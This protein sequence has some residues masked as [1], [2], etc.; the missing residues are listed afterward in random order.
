MI[1]TNGFPKAGNHALVK[2]CELL[3]AKCAVN[4]TPFGEELPG[5]ATHSLFIVRDPRDIVISFLRFTGR[6]VTAA[7]FMLA[8]REFR[9]GSS[10]MAELAK[11]EGWLSSGSLIVRYEDLIADERE[12]RRIAAFIGVEYWPRLWEEL[13]GLTWTWN[14]VHSDY[15]ALW[16]AELEAEWASAGGNDLLAIWGYEP[17]KS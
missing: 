12:M 9:P 1:F 16:T 2:A 15:R 17:W 5:A 11:Y 3:G 6:P 4:H 10:L 13:P 8:V 7:A 14:P